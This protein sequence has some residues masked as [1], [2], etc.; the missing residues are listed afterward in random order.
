MIA[1]YRYKIRE[2]TRSFRTSFQEEADNL[3]KELDITFN[4]VLEER[5]DNATK[6]EEQISELYSAAAKLEELGAMLKA[7]R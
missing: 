3:Q 2:S 6:I 7:P 4:R 1:D 5:K